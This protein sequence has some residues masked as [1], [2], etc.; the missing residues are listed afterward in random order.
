M[1]TIWQKIK[2]WL[3]GW[4]LVGLIGLVIVLLIVRGVYKSKHDTSNI[5]TDTVK[6]QDLKQTVL[7]T[8][9]VTSSTDLNLSFKASGNVK[10]VNAV[11][12]KKVFTGAILATLDQKDQAATL[13][14]ARGSLAA[15]Q[16]NYNK[17]LSGAS[18]EDIALSQAAVDAATANLDNTKAQ[19]K[20]LVANA[21]SALMN[22]GLAAIPA[23]SINSTA[24][25]TISGS[26][27][28]AEQGSY[29]L[30]FYQT[31]NGLYYNLSGL[32]SASGPVT[33]GVPTPLGNRGLFVTFG[34]TGDFYSS[35]SWNI[36]VPN[37]QS[38]GYTTYLNAYQS[39][40]Q[41]QTSAVSAA[42]SSLLQAQ[43]TLNLKKA[44]ARPAELQAA[45]AQVLS[46][47]GQYQAALASLENTII[48]A[49]AAGTITKV[50]IKVGQSINAFTSAIVLQNIDQL[51][52]EANISEANVAQIQQG[53]KVDV[54]LDALGPDV[55]YSATV[56]NLD[57]SSTV[58]SGVVNYKL[59][60]TL[61]KPQDIR[62]GMTA[63]MTIL[64]NEKLEVVAIPQRS[65][66]DRDG[67]KFVRVVT[68]TK[69]K[70]Y[71]EREVTTGLSADGGLVEINSGLSE[72]QEIIT[73]INKS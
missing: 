62:P 47:Q 58:V 42:E 39:A 55:H 71:A 67:K 38:S 29:K 7:A 13:T 57:L 49:P 12:G 54:T 51:H 27:S 56:T 25:V 15:A 8:G 19:Q 5:L 41:T 46:A 23:G 50:D 2:P 9:V 44:Q 73:F 11:V 6:K 21:L 14:S 64:T 63:N 32:E 35:D 4:R 65:V 69:T 40:L 70:K 26:Y 37:P 20:V 1:K 45:Q 48:R 24:T 22:T 10:T 72:G 68:D 34:S 66:I 17:V 18:N 43:A 30:A 61:D 52:L 16:A 53:Q 60:A 36:P 3:K 31:G 59:T 28:S 33:R